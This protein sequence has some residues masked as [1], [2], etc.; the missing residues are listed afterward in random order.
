MGKYGDEEIISFLE[1]AYRKFKI[2]TKIGVDAENRFYKTMDGQMIIAWR[3]E[4]T[5]GEN[6]DLDFIDIEISRELTQKIGKCVEKKFWEK[7][8]SEKPKD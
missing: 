2:E 7:Y 3:I 1:E 5:A 4:G 6:R 8:P